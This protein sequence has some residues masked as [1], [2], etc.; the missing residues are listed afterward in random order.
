MTPMEKLVEAGYPQE[1][2]Y[3]HCS[4][5]YLFANSLTQKVINEWF[6]EQQMDRTLFVSIFTDQITGKPMYNV[7]FQYTPYWNSVAER[8]EEQEDGVS[9]K[10]S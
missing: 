4:D 3:H 1:H 10:D 2:F 9:E 8:K 6:E 7:A 5:L